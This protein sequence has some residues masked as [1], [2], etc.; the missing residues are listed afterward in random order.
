MDV[1]Q[2]LLSTDGRARH[3]VDMLTRSTAAIGK[4]VPKDVDRTEIG[5]ED[6]WFESVQNSRV[7]LQAR[8]F[9]LTDIL[10][11]WSSTIALCS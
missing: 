5:L 3:E 4:L 6:S 10:R 1:A 9:I 2:G 7:G 8:E 11:P